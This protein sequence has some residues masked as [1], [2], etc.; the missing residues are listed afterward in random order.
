MASSEDSETVGLKRN[1]TLF[2]GSTVIVGIIVGSGIF[3]SPTGVLMNC[4]SVGAALIIWL[5]CGIICLIGALCLS[6]LG[7]MIADSGGIYAYL[8]EA[9]GDFCAFLYMWTCMIVIFPAANAVISLVFA[10]YILYPVFPCGAPYIPVRLIAAAA[11]LFLTFINCWSVKASTRIQ[12]VFTV[13]K[14]LALVLIILTGVVALCQGRVGNFEDMFNGTVTDPGRISLAFY[15]GMF[16]YSGWYTLNFLT[17]ELQNPFKNLPRAIWISMPMITVIYTTVNVAYFAVLSVPEILE[18][19]AVA[20]TFANRMYGVLAFTMPIFVSFSCF[21]SLN[22]CLMSVSRMFYVSARNGHLPDLM[23]L[24]NMK[25]YTPLPA[26]L[27]QGILSLFMLLSDDVYTLINCVSFVEA[28][29]FLMF[30]LA[31]LKFRY[32]RPDAKRPIKVNICLPI[33][34]LIVTLFLTIVPMYGSPRD[35]GI[36]LAFMASGIPVYIIGVKWKQKPEKFTKWM[37]ALTILGQKLMLGV[38]QDEKEE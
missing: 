19:D 14:I 28:L 25:K 18:S 37:K 24:I 16:S 15:S 38:M 7:T 27:S 8:K 30:T 20:V 34:Y 9:F 2:N 4:G 13:I 10:Q 21:G 26:V 35:T 22:G 12:D 5:V 17:E 23:A 11:I 29:S 6:E 1:L 36:G 31:L 32:T 3:V 33:F